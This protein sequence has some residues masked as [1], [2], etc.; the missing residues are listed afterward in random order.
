[1]AY[2]FNS[3]KGKVN[4]YTTEETYTKEEIDDSKIEVSDFLVEKKYINISIPA[5]WT[6]LTGSTQT[7]VSKTGYKALGVVGSFWD[8]SAGSQTVDKTAYNNTRV[9]GPSFSFANQTINAY[10]HK[11]TGYSKALTAEIIAWVL[12]VK[13]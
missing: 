7:N 13:E 6:G 11:G 9:M 12:Y 5:N 3:D 4:V 1:M 10:I 2:A 8:L